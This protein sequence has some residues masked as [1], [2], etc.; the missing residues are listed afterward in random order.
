MRL[1]GSMADDAGALVRYNLESSAARHS[2][3]LHMLHLNEH[4]SGTHP[5]CQ[6]HQG[7]DP[8]NQR[9]A[10]RP[11]PMCRGQTRRQ[12]FGGSQTGVKGYGIPDADHVCTNTDRSEV[13]QTIIVGLRPTIARE[14]EER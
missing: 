13:N 6:S 4:V 14:E 5:L 3:L 10:A 12:T 2:R 8:R 11:A 1:L 9:I 7:V